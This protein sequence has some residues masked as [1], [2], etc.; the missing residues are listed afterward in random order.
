MAS[1]P[2]GLEKAYELLQPYY[3]QVKVMGMNPIMKI[4]DFSQSNTP[5]Q[6]STKQNKF[7]HYI[8]SAWGSLA[9]V[10]SDEVCRKV[11]QVSKLT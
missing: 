9:K 5:G 3:I 2:D 11:V 10:D 4:V 1:G 8:S 7:K 6:N